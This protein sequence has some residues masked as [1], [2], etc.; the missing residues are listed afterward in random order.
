MKVYVI[1][2][3]A[4]WGWYGNPQLVKVFKNK[5]DAEQFVRASEDPNIYDIE[6]TEGVG[7]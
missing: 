3:I 4:R 6:E 7:F 1:T 5:T 2:M